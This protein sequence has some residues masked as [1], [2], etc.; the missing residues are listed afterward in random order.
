MNKLILTRIFKRKQFIMLLLAT[1]IINYF[2][3]F[4]TN[5]EIT[6]VNLFPLQSA[7]NMN[8]MMTG[9]STLGGIMYLFLSFIIASLALSDSL[10]EDRKSGFENQLLVRMN[11]RDYLRS[12]YIYNFIFGGLFVIFPY[13][14]NILLWLMVRPMFAMNYISA[15]LINQAFLSD[16]FIKS[17]VLFLLVHIFIVFIVGGIMSSLALIINDKFNNKYVGGLAVLIIDIIA[18]I[19]NQIY[20]FTTED[21]ASFVGLKDLVINRVLPDNLLNWMYILLAVFIPILY[22]IKKSRKEEII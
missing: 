20:V 13:L 21:Y 8:M 22:L 16:L 12:I 11:K 5:N 18:S 7:W 9:E 6:Y 10:V 19:L 1:V 3:F 17:P 4:K 15:S 14:I 2:N